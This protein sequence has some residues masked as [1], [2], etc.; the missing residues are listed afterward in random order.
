MARALDLTLSY[1]PMLK[2]GQFHSL[3]AKYRSFAGGWGNGKTSAGC[4]E[5]FALLMEYPGT[6]CIISRKTRP[7]LRSTTWDMWVNGDKS[8]PKGWHGVPKELII[9]HRQSDLYMELMTPTGIPSKV[10]GLPLDDPAKLE[11]F[12]L[13][14]FWIDQAEEI[15]EELFLKFH[16]RLRQMAGPRQGLLTWNPAGHSWL[17]HRFIDP[18][19][20]DKWKRIYQAIEASTYDNPNLPEDYLEQFEGLPE[21]WIKRFVE[22]SHDVFVG[23]IFTS[24]DPDLH[25]IRPFRIPEH[26]QRFMCI[27]PGIRH[28]GAVV[29]M[30]RS[31]DNQWFVYREHLEANRDVRWWAEF[32]KKAEAA[33][34]WGGP[35]EIIPDAHRWIGPESQ[36]R[37]QTDGRTVLDLWY[38]EG[39]FPQ[40]ADRDPSARISAISKGLT[41]DAGSRHPATGAV[42]S[43]RLYVFGTC[44]W[45]QRY[46]PQYRWRPQRVN[47]TEEDSA[48]KPRK[49]DDHNIDCLGH[50]LLGARDIPALQDDRSVDRPAGSPAAQLESECWEHAQAIHEG[51]QTH[52]VL[53]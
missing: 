25:V 1:E 20:P 37:A 43:P 2:Q 17:W 6:N 22:G 10:W 50:I 35:E 27:D 3:A 4:A 9:T 8:Q 28:E 7:E 26:W 5:T 34:D 31:P 24:Y 14:L 15:E 11:N 52:D 38:D 51:R 39:F 32:T 42:P 12:N 48:E 44:G 46:L 29:W 21:M 53:A 41:G 19:R 36:Q 23:Q 47:Y 49:K 45:M 16:G 33:D 40:I 30:A 18:K 13:G